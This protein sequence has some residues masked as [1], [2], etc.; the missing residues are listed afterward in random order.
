[1]TTKR[2]LRRPSPQ[3]RP[4]DQLSLTAAVSFGGLEA[5]AAS[6]EGGDATPKAPKFSMLAYS[7][8]PMRLAGFRDPVVIDLAGLDLGVA[9]L[10]ILADHMPY[11]E[12]AVGH[13]TSKIVANG[14]LQVE[15][16]ISGVGEMRD[17]IVALAKNGFPWQA[18]V[19]FSVSRVERVEAGSSANVNGKTVAGPLNV[20]RASRLREVSFVVLG[21][22]D[23]TTSRV[24]ASASKGDLQMEPKTGADGQTGTAEAQGAPAPNAVDAMNAEIAANYQ[25]VAAIQAT[26]KDHPE[27]AAQAIREKWTPERAELAVLRA[28]RPSAGAPAVHV[29][30]NAVKPD[31]ILAAAMLS[32]KIDP[33]KEGLS[34]QAVDLAAKQYR[35]GIGLTE[36]ILECARANGYDRR[37]VRGDEGNM[38]RA[39]FSTMEISGILSN[40][41]NKVLLR[42]FE[43]VEQVWRKIANVVPVKDFKT[44][45]AY[46]LT[47]SMKFEKVSPAGELRHGKAGQE[48]YTISADSFGKL[49]AITRQDLINDDLGALTG[50]A[51]RL[52]RGAGWWRCACRTGTSPECR[53]RW[54]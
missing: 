34:P 20:V 38:L 6:P 50:Q 53:A 33:L 15:G 49:F 48:S 47:G 44:V 19:G 28:S 5:A 30:D 22:D 2:E 51:K 36:I 7:G 8:G 12:Y 14:S 9:S 45:T 21:A 23:Q 25:R 29:A 35:H 13:T 32:A 42:S 26:C 43:A 31:T 39:A 24:A 16:V 11:A 54:R 37:S 52:G 27:I 3:D 4:Q 46:R 40:V 10:P 41:G 17:R 18:S 1:M